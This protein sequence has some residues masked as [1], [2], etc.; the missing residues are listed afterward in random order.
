MPPASRPGPDPDQQLEWLLLAQGPDRSKQNVQTGPTE[1]PEAT[2][3]HPTRGKREQTDEDTK[4][5]WRLTNLH[6]GD[7]PNPG[8]GERFPVG[9]LRTGGQ[10]PAPPT[11]GKRQHRPL[12]DCHRRGTERDPRQ[13]EKGTEARGG[14]RKADRTEGEKGLGPSTDGERPRDER[15]AAQKPREAPAYLA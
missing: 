2:P 15:P 5:A 8:P 9:P 14:K 11:P 3:P 13:P 10:K 1:A 7:S 6:K 4:E 12:R